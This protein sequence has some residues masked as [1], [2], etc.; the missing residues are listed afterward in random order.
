MEQTLSKPCTAILSYR[1]VPNSFNEIKN[2]TEYQG[3]WTTIMA[4]GSFRQ[5]EDSY[6]DLRAQPSCKQ[7]STIQR[8]KTLTSLCQGVPESALYFARGLTGPVDLQAFKD[9]A[10]TLQTVQL[11]QCLIIEWTSPQGNDMS[12]GI[13]RSASTPGIFR[14]LT[15][16][17][18]PAVQL[19]SVLNH[20]F[21]RDWFLV[22]QNN[23]DAT[24]TFRTLT[25]SSPLGQVS[26]GME[27]TQSERMRQP[28]RSLATLPAVSIPMPLAQNGFD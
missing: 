26:R 27:S 15:N 20:I 28:F 9:L 13:Y 19:R 16:V 17:R 25:A 10:V 21:S 3:G 6:K 22:V 12:I 18:D 23:P 1:T 2:P 14:R 5:E 24:L 11:E 7:H 4:H 8:L